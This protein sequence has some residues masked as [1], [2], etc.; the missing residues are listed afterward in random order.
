MT[1]SRIAAAS[2]STTQHHHHQQ[3]LRAQ[4]SNGQSSQQGADFRHCLLSSVVVCSHRGLGSNPEQ[5]KWFAESERVHARWA[6]LA[7]AGILTQVRTGQC[8]WAMRLCCSTISSCS[9]TGSGSTS[10]RQQRLLRSQQ[11]QLLRG[12]P[13]ATP[14]CCAAGTVVAVEVAD[15]AG[16]L[17]AASPAFLM[18]AADTAVGR[19]RRLALGI[20]HADW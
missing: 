17:H 15:T 16:C 6:M 5:L 11:L 2:K 9:K 4:P 14:L 20:H 19:R 1:A 8:Q 3:E 13:A 7:V 10:L 12:W 18:Q